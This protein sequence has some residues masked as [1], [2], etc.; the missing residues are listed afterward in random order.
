MRR[1]T[2]RQLQVFDAVAR[3]MSFSHAS[4][5]LHLTQ[6]AVSLQIKQLE[7][8]TSL[9]LFEQV[10]R[11]LFLTDAGETLL[12]HTRAILG[13]VA[14]AEEAMAAL[15]GQRAGGPR[16]GVVSTAK[17]FAPHL[18]SAFGAGFPGV[19]LSLAVANRGQI[20]ADLAENRIDLAL[21]GRPPEDMKVEA[22]A[23]APHPHVFIAPPTHKLLGRKIPIE[24]LNGETFLMREQGSGTRLLMERLMG[25]HGITAGRIMEMASNETIK[26][27]VM[28]GMGVSFLS[29]HTIGLEVSV[30]RLAILEV[31]DTPVRRDW[32]VVVR[33]GKKLLPV[34]EAFVAFLRHHG[35]RLIEEAT[36]AQV[37][38]RRRASSD[39]V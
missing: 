37:P 9:P 32:F 15:R 5:E 16:V 2:L 34:G 26:Q 35:A 30:G 36:R 22:S 31:K 38:R 27:A 28:A 33:Q 24:D 12:G 20:I 8:L 23:F 4:R 3:H 19:D 14:D 39:K 21:M 17:Y 29:R 6:P 18:L 25:E 7:G 13:A 10:G 1:T 11:K